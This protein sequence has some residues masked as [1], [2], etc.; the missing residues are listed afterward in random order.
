M[1]WDYVQ[2]IDPW[3]NFLGLGFLG[4]DGESSS[5]LLRIFVK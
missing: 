2:G 5:L 4:S 1:I 3:H